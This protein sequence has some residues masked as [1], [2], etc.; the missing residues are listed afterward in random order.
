MDLIWNGSREAFRLLIHL[1]S[2]VLDAAFRSLWISVFAV[3]VA[4]FI[5]VPLGIGLARVNFPCKR[6]LVVGC[7][8]CMAFPTVFVG[9]V[10]FALFSRRGPLGPLELL[11]TPWVIVWG[12][13]LLALPMIV[14]ITH[15][16]IKSL[17]PRV[18]ETAW[19]LGANRFRRWGTYVS[20]ARVGVVLAVLTAFSRCVT[21]LGIAMMV[22][23][24]IK[25]R[26]RTLATATA[27]ETG[28][29]EFGRGMA[30]SLILL[31]IAMGVTFFIV[32]LSREE[33]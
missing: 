13:F 22:G 16:A 33:D 5:G 28:K 8:S 21:E 3:S 2:A 31:T 30:M 32:L 7:R 19:T 11:Y 29:G 20:E 24:N 4:T 25:D 17:D 6:L 1:D 12:E 14:S 18:S 10:C 15:G 26:T 27:L 9:L 23:G